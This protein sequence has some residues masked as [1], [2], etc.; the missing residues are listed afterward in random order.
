MEETAGFEPAAV[1]F[2]KLLPWTTRAC[3]HKMSNYNC[4]ERFS[5][6]SFLKLNS[7]LYDDSLDSDRSNQHFLMRHK[8][9]LTSL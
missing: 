7:L 6:Q 1:Q 5:C 8:V 9:K 3:L 4:L 2:C